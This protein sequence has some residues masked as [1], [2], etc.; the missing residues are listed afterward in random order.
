M[1]ACLIISGCTTTFRPWNLSQIHEGMGREQVVMI[2]GDPDFTEV[3]NGVEEMHYSYQ[4]DYNPSA[5]SIPFYDE[6]TDMAFRDLEN[7]RRFRQYE[8]VVT[9]EKGT[10]TGYEER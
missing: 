7:G 4:E 10:V 1:V 2:L 6:K 3:R 9:L 5:A 8:Y